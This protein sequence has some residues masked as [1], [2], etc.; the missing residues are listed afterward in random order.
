[1]GKAHL[2]RLR[3]AYSIRQRALLRIDDLE[4]EFAAIAVHP[5]EILRGGL[6]QG[7]IDDMVGGKALAARR[8]SLP[9]QLSEQQAALFLRQVGNAPG[10]ADSV[11]EARL[12]AEMI[13][14]GAI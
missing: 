14:Q 5:A 13:E 10:R 11:E 6:V 1:H 7:S 8:I 2:Q 4:Q 12:A 9:V 3:W